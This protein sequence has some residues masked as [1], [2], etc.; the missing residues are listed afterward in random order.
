MGQTMKR[1]ALIIRQ[2][3]TATKNVKTQQS[4]MP[5]TCMHVI[6]KSIAQTAQMK[7]DAMM[8]SHVEIEQVV[9]EGTTNALWIMFVLRRKTICA[10][11]R[12]G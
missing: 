12:V 9:M 4:T 11:A 10:H 8:L 7:K 2:A 1:N 6:M 5:N 3:F